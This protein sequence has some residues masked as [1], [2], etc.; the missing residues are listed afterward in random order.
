MN[1]E[2]EFWVVSFQALL[3]NKEIIDKGM[4]WSETRKHRINLVYGIQNI[5]KG[6][7][8]HMFICEQNPH[9]TL[10]T[11]LDK[12]STMWKLFNNHFK[13]V[14]VFCPKAI[15]QSLMADKPIPN[16]LSA[17]FIII[18]NIRLTKE[19]IQILELRYFLS[20]FYFSI[21]SVTRIRLKC[22]SGFAVF[23]FYTNVLTLQIV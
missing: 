23:S 8:L 11:A 16:S 17:F 6:I 15:D 1:F 4:T 19:I 22:I 18:L 5:L 10:K 9:E 2:H 12:L 7:V 14:F 3:V 21:V 20:S 13:I